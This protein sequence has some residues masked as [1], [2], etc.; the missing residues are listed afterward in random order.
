MIPDRLKRLRAILEEKKLDALLVNKLVHLHYFSGFRGDDSV[1]IIT[2][3]KALL[4]TDSRYVEQAGQQAPLF[5][6]VKQEEGLWKK[7]AECL[8]SLGCRNVGFEGD[9]LY[10]NDYAR[11]AGLL[12]GI[13]FREA[14]DLGA[15]RQ[16]KEAEEISSIRRAC[17]IADR[18]FEDVLGF[19]RPGISEIEVAA[20]LENCMRQLG[21]EEPSFTTIVASGERGSLPHGIATEKLIVAGEFVTMDY[22]AV[23]QGYHSD[24]TRT[25]CMGTA[26][27]RQREI[28]GNVLKAQLAALGA[29]R[30]GVSGRSVDQVARDSLERDGLVQYFGHGLGHSLG[31]EIHEEPRLSPHSKCEQLEPGMLV[32]DEPGVY[33]PGWGGLRIEDTVLVTET[34]GEPLTRSSKQLIELKGQ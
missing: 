19:L 22:G 12:E 20:H 1:L 25:V 11:M 7:A 2:G 29:I 34:G 15:L 26:D 3:S 18:A 9:A 13:G 23:Y 27:G 17:E 16:V 28:Y 30:A 31:L 6:V 33:I 24:I 32:T 8:R 5:E 14:V 21:S 10:Y 4:V